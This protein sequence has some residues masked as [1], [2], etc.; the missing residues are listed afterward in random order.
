MKGTP[1]MVRE[2][3]VTGGLKYIGREVQMDQA[4]TDETNPASSL[5]PDFT[6]QTLFLEVLIEGR[7]SLF[8]YD[9]PHN[10]RYF[11]STDTVPLN[12]LIF[13]YYR[14]PSDELI[15]IRTN[16]LFRQ[17]L[18][19]NIPRKEEDITFYEKI[20]YEKNDLKKYVIGYNAGN[21]YPFVVYARKKESP[22]FSLRVT[23]GLSIGT[24]KVKDENKES[25]FTIPARYS[26]RA[27]LETELMFPYTNRKVALVLEPTYYSFVGSEYYW[28][29][30]YDVTLHTIEFPI[31]VRYYMYL[32]H[33]IRIFL[34]A[35]YVPSLSAEIHSEIN[36]G[37]A[38]YTVQTRLCMAAGAG[39]GWKRFGLEFRMYTPHDL[40]YG[41]NFFYEKFSR[42]EVVAGFR[43]FSIK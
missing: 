35:L 4:G 31:G 29:R 15:I 2:F 9:Q 20:E 34:N 37:E 32:T 10:T 23:P 30:Y 40:C 1:A 16:T 12:Q 26:F 33:D 38:V 7:A 8:V 43:L 19:K 5:E 18:W 28:G 24:V 27:G 11:Y 17:Q 21:G 25:L 14:L 39:V 13:R 36:W 3:A 42:M 6:R 22:E 41:S